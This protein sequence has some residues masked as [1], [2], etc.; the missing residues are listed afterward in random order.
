MCSKPHWC[1]N[2]SHS[3]L[4]FIQ[5]L[6][7]MLI[8]FSMFSSYSGCWKVLVL[9]LLGLEPKTDQTDHQTWFKDQ[10]P[11]YG[12]SEIITKTNIKSSPQIVLI[13]DW[14]WNSSC[15]LFPTLSLYQLSQS[16]TER[17]IYTLIHIHIYI[18]IRVK[19]S[20]T[21]LSPAILV[22]FTWT[23]QKHR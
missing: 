22:T 2:K 17:Y 8:L 1:N 18:Y 16:D 12:T 5:I 20:N 11:N 6:L 7:K 21:R 14:I 19:T 23:I 10:C 3:N 15:L 9:W 4:C 13:A